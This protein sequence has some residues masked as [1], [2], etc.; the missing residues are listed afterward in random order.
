MLYHIE[1]EPALRDIYK[2][3][4]LMLKLFPS[5]ERCFSVLGLIKI[6]LRT[7]LNQHIFDNLLGLS[8]NPKLSFDEDEWKNIVDRFRDFGA[9]RKIA[10]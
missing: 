8:L 3:L 5:V 10:L 2:D 6:K 7:R 9:T 4:Y 1:S